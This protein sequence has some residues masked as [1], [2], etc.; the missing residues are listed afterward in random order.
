M[1]N[2]GTQLT[3][4]ANIKG[5]EK[6]QSQTSKV[7]TRVILAFACVLFFGINLANADGL[8]V[9]VSVPSSV[10]S[11]V[12]FNIS[13]NVLNKTPNQITF[14]K[15]AVGYVLPDLKIKGPY[16]IDSQ[17]H[18]VPGNNSI[19]ISVPFKI[20]FTSGSIVPLSVVLAKDTYSK[21][22]ILGGDVVGVKVIAAQ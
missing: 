19:N 15:V 11:G 12:P 7:V 4:V 6:M 9:T 14:N 17:V 5:E 21:N 18:N 13:I 10:Y 16:E 20:N 2:Q 8:D 22:G 1:A 3:E